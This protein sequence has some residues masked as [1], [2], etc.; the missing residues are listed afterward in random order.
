MGPEAK[1]KAQVKAILKSHR[2]WYFMPV[3]QGFGMPALDFH[4]HHKG[5]AF[6]IET[7]APGKK[8]TTRQEIT[9]DAIRRAGGKTFVIDGS[10]YSKL[11]CWLR[12]H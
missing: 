1:V 12:E 3:Q 11:E 9:M 6:G 2:A 4:G 7:K 10:D 8:P 5:R